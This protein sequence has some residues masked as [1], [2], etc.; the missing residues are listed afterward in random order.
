MESTNFRKNR[1]VEIPEKSL[2]VIEYALL[3]LLNNSLL[4]FC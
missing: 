1:K 2:L 4:L 3:E